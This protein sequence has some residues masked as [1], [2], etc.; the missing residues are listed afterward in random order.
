[1]RPSGK[2]RAAAIG[3][4]IPFFE[5]RSSSITTLLRQV[6]EEATVLESQKYRQY[7]A[8]CIRLSQTMSAADK[9][10]LLEI[11]A[12]WEKRAQEADGDE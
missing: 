7:A 3:S 6:A 8:D 12:A 2:I 11:A 1:R 9:L 5:E 4:T 10:R